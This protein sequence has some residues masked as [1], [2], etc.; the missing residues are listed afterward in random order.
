MAERLRRPDYKQRKPTPDRRVV[1]AYSVEYNPRDPDRLPPECSWFHSE[2]AEGRKCVTMQLE[3][4][5]VKKKK[6]GPYWYAYLRK[7]R[8]TY[9]QPGE[10]ISVYVGKPTGK[11]RRPS[12]K[13]LRGA[14]VKLR[15]AGA[16]F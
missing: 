9:N 13:D 12:G 15:N 8:E 7:P 14:M 4:Q 11:R 10:L 5:P 6:Y 2:R 3:W 1:N 16:F